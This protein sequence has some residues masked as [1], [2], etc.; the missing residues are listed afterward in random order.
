MREAC[1][2]YARRSVIGG[3][4]GF[5]ALGVLPGMAQAAG[6]T[7]QLRLHHLHT[8]E[9]LDVTYM[10]NGRYDP[11]ALLQ[12][13]RIMRD[14]RDDRAIRIDH[15]L[16]DQM[17]FLQEQ[18][19]SESRYEVFCGYRTERTNALLRRRGRGVAKR[20]YHLKGQAVDLR[21]PGVR[22]R[23]LRSYAV[24]MNAG[25]VGY[26]PRSDFIHLDTGA[27]RTW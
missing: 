13:D 20:S 10:R 19:G 5:G 11:S 25:G 22:L 9:K 23:Q 1:T 15:R 27:V 3:V 16:V 24:S 14:W 17:A 8:D 26:Y 18:L 21:L 6:A 2:A 4:L 12:V 7:R